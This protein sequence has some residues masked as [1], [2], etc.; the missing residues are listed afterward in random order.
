MEI[1]KFYDEMNN[2]VLKIWDDIVKMDTKREMFDDRETEWLQAMY[3]KSNLL[4]Y[5]LGKDMMSKKDQTHQALE[6]Y[7]KSVKP[8]KKKKKKLQEH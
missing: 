8:Q 5:L 2:I 4:V 1:M 3:N 6:S 7:R